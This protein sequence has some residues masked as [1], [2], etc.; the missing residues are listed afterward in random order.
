MDG[1]NMEMTM[2]EVEVQSMFLIKIYLI[3]PRYSKYNT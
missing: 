2:N 1:F 3:Q